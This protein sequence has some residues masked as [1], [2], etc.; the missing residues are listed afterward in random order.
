MHTYWMLLNRC[1]ILLIKFVVKR[2]ALDIV[3]LAIIKFKGK[4]I[5]N[6]KICLNDSVD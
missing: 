5:K 3:S 1:K 4:Y 2:A 6:I